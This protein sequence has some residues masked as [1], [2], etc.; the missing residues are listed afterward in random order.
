MP[1]RIFAICLHINEAYSVY[2]YTASIKKK[3]IGLSFLQLYLSP[4]TNCNKSIFHTHRAFDQ[5]QLS[6]NSQCIL[7]YGLD[8]GEGEI[9]YETIFGCTF[10]INMHNAYHEFR[11]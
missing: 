6:T 10:T 11:I 1:T 9:R 4:M 7:V 2:F 3:I 5:Y 8:Q